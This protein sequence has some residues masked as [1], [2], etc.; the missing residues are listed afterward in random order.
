MKTNLTEQLQSADEAAVKAALSRVTHHNSSEVIA[1]LLEAWSAH[2]A[3]REAI[4]KL[5]FHLR[6]PRCVEPLV[7]ATQQGA[8]SII[9]L[10]SIWQSGLDASAHVVE[11]ARLAATGSYAEA[12]EVMAVLDLCESITDEHCQ[13]AI[14][15]LDEFLNKPTTDKALLNAIKQ[16]LLDALLN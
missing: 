4:E 12:V 16:M 11:L 15:L 14:K 8:T 2:Y 13:E 1:A 5:L 9:A 10:S 3:L 7:K 6:D